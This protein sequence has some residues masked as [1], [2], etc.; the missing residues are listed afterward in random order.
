MAAP[1][2]GCAP[3]RSA[4]PPPRISLAR[5]TR[6]AGAGLRA[7]TWCS[8]PW[9]TPTAG[10][11]S[12]RDTTSTPRPRWTTWPTGSATRWP[13]GSAP[14]R[15]CRTAPGAPDAEAAAPP[16]PVAHPGGRAG[17]AARRAR[18]R[19][20]LGERG[21]GRR[22]APARAMGADRYGRG[23]R[24]AAHPWVRGDRRLDR[25]RGE[26]AGPGYEWLGHDGT[27]LLRREHA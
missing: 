9:G 25:Q 6:S 16:P 11:C 15:R 20:R 12:A 14:P 23:W 7:P 26:R 10:R 3:C 1:S 24:V 2:R 8:P 13:P 27:R 5:A 17:R 21:A 19:R 18:R 4:A 22:R